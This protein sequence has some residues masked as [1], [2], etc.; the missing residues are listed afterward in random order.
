MADFLVCC[1]GLNLRE[2]KHQRWVKDEVQLT[3][4]KVIPSAYSDGI[5]GYD[6]IS[7]TLMKLKNEDS[8]RSTWKTH[9][10]FYKDHS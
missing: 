4:S 9:H 3:A 10:P 5:H 1:E 7:L 2:L 8:H 6:T